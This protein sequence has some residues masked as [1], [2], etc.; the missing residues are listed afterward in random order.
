MNEEVGFKHDGSLCRSTR[1][2]AEVKRTF[3]V[4]G[5]KCHSL[6]QGNL[7][8]KITQGKQKMWCLTTGGL[9]KQVHEHVN[10]IKTTGHYRQL[11]FTYT[12]L[13]EQA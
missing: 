3:G 5:V 8:I 7:S 13:L 12:W 4:Q 10:G 6:V 1:E 2:H 11:V 9:Y